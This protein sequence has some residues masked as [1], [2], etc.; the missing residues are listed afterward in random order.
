VSF[1]QFSHCKIV[2]FGYYVHILSSPTFTLLS[3]G[4]NTKR[5]GLLWLWGFHTLRPCRSYR[6]HTVTSDV[7]RPKPGHQ[8]ALNQILYKVLK[9][10][11]HHSSLFWS[12]EG[13]E[14][15]ALC[16]VVTVILPECTTTLLACGNR[17]KTINLR[18]KTLLKYAPLT[19][20]AGTRSHIPPCLFIHGN[21]LLRSPFSR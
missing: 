19:L 10:H 6:F 20:F 14:P 4:L 21:L 17:P 1:K 8:A 11:R 12:R 2:T 18:F 9:L 15:I 16:D 13:F 5:L 7:I 3:S